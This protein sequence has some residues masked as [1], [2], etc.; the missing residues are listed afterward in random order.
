M[1]DQVVKYI[2]AKTREGWKRESEGNDKEGYVIKEEKV[3]KG[4][5]P[6]G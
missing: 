6:R 5:L 4:V 1:N 3:N 2:K